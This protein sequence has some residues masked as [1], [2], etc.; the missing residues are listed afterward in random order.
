MG[1]FSNLKKAFNAVM[2]DDPMDWT[3]QEEQIR[4]LELLCLFEIAGNLDTIAVEM[5]EQSKILRINSE[6]AEK[7]VKML[8]EYAEKISKPVPFPT[9][10]LKEPPQFDRRNK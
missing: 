3:M 2:P 4:H 5:R 9:I 10:P 7:Q 6:R 8:E 1:G